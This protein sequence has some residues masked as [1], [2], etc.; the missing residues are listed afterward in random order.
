MENNKSQI[1]DMK[2][3]LNELYLVSPKKE[4]RNIEVKIGGSES[5]IHIYFKSNLNT[6]GNVK[7]EK[8]KMK[9]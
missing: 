9:K 8:K 5:D 6:E 2:K 7:K 1:P 3:I 4:S